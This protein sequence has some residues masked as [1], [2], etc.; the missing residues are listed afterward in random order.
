MNYDQF[1]RSV[2][3]GNQQPSRRKVFVSHS[4]IHEIENDAFLETFG[5]VFIP[6]ALGVNDADDFIDSDDTDYVM[7]RIRELYVEDSTVTIVLI[8]SC[9]HSRRYVDWEIKASLKRGEDNLPN[10]LLG[11]TLPSTNGSAHLPERFK[12]NWNEDPNKSY[13]SYWPYPQTKDQLRGWIEEAFQRRSSHVRL[14]QNPQE[15][16]SS[17]RRCNICR[18]TH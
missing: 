18:I 5:D 10:G 4:H 16:W 12:L 7:Q 6:K 8:G 1:L 15:R 14:V 9:V 11:I 13:A 3:E 17:N 2:L